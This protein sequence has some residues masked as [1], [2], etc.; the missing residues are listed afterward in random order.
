MNPTQPVEI[1]VR[2]KVPTTPATPA[3]PATVMVAER[4]DGVA[5]SA[6]WDSSQREGGTGN[7]TMN[8]T[9]LINGNSLQE[10]GL[11]QNVPM[12]STGGNP[13]G[14]EMQGVMGKQEE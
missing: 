10:N 7:M 5:Q 12:N 13:S 2:V 8:A 4:G 9:P 3:M 14:I 11:T 1:K 6:T